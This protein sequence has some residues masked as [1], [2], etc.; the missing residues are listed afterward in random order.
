MHGC[1]DD[2]VDVAA[3]G[4]AAAFEKVGVG[5]RGAAVVGF[6]KGLGEGLCHLS[7]AD[8]SFEEEVVGGWMVVGEGFAAHLDVATFKRVAA[9]VLNRVPRSCQYYS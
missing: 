2:A 4:A 9:H 8:D 6:A 1:F 3:K 7:H 5:F